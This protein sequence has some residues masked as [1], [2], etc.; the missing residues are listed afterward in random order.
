MPQLDDIKPQLDDI[1]LAESCLGGDQQDC[2]SLFDRHRQVL[3]IYI[4]KKVGDHEVA[5]DLT[6]ETLLR[7]YR[8]LRDFEWDS[9]FKTWLFSIAINQF[10]DYHRR[11]HAL[12]RLGDEVP[13]GIEEDID[14]NLRGDI[15]AL[16]EKKEKM[17]KVNAGIQQLPKR[18]REILQLTQKGLNYNEIVHKLKISRI[19]VGTNKT[20]ALKNLRAILK[21]IKKDKKK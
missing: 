21:K 3:F 5:R 7:A 11:K 17:D 14:K 8:G 16:I 18:Q 13:F 9:S 2:N 12:K 19:A 10:R 6:Q 1:D 20:E 4:K 15:E